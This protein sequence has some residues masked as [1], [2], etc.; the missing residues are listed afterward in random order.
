MA[1]VLVLTLTVATWADDKADKKD[2]KVQ[3]KADKK[4]NK[5]KIIGTWKPVSSKEEVT[6]EFTKD[7]KLIIRSKKGGTDME[8]EAKYKVD[9]DKLSITVK[10]GDDERT[11]TAT[12]KK[13][14]DDELV[15][16]NPKKV[17]TTFKRVK[18]KKS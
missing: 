17:K 1:G 12:I 6:L 10:I 4:T 13:L 8:A 15:T 7:G 14:D 16:E 9:G 18:K 2:Q 11:R 5:E 3:K